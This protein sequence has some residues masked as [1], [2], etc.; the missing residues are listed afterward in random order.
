MKRVAQ[1]VLLVVFGASGDLAKRKLIPALYH[2]Y[3]QGLL[4]DGFALLGF[5]RT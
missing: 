4:H 3:S 5:A 1:P 2:L